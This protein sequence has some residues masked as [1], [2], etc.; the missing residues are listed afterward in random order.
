MA[1]E[2]Q[3][4]KLRAFMKRRGPEVTLTVKQ[5]KNQLGIFSTDTLRQLLIEAHVTGEIVS[6]MLEE[7]ENGC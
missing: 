6:E 7:T 3:W 5:L 1:T 4:S 2:K